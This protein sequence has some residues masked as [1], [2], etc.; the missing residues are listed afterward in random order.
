L[1]D[2]A[3]FGF[4]QVVRTWLYL[5]DIIGQE[6]DRQRYHELNRAR[7]DYFRRVSFQNPPGRNGRPFYPASTGVGAEGRGM[8]MSCV[9]LRSDRGDCAVVALE[10]PCQTSAFDY[11]ACHSPASPRFS[12]AAAVILDDLATV[13]ISGT[14]SIVESRSLHPGDVERQTDQTLDNIASL[15]GEENY[16][17]HGLNGFGATLADLAKMRV[18]LKRASDYPRVRELCRRRVGDLPVVYT[19]ADICRPEL[20]V[21]I[22]ALA[23][24]RRAEQ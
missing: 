5:G 13:F 21:E 9:A 22:E 14:A 3:G 23:Y 15:I 20:L 18:Y 19:V 1:L 7:A 10:N 8:L 17:S 6:G 2:A 24:A 11:A 12:R 4:G 16:Q